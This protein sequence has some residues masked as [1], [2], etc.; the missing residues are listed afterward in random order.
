MRDICQPSITMHARRGGWPHLAPPKTSLAI[1][2][3]IHR[4]TLATQHLRHKFHTQIPPVDSQRLS[5]SNHDWRSYQ[6]D[7]Y[8]FLELIFG[9]ET[10]QMIRGRP[11]RN[12]FRHDIRSRGWSVFGRIT[13]AEAETSGLLA[14]CLHGDLIMMF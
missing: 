10:E 7:D 3:H 13:L 14:S 11:R 2:D 8:I 6:P 1:A 12:S 9:E 4:R 5:M